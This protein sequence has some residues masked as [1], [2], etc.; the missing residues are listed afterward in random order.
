MKFWSWLEVIFVLLV[1]IFFL[2]SVRG[3]YP[4]IKQHRGQLTSKWRKNLKNNMWPSDS[5]VPILTP[6]LC[7][8][9]RFTVSYMFEL[10]SLAPQ[11][12][13]TNAGLPFS[14]WWNLP[15]SLQCCFPHSSSKKTT[16]CHVRTA[17]AWLIT[18]PL[19]VEQKPLFRQLT[20]WLPGSRHSQP[21][22]GSQK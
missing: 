22:K 12:N 8:P 6:G 14:L 18:D 13:L 16:C 2:P 19:S 5:G 10:M 21:W 15:L 9:I 17:L 1:V 11:R 4:R 20:S 3:V 7:E